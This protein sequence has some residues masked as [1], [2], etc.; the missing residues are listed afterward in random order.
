MTGRQLRAAIRK[1][2]LGSGEAWTPAPGSNRAV[3]ASALDAWCRF[4]ADKLAAAGDGYQT[5]Q[6]SRQGDWATVVAVAEFEV[7]TEDF[8]AEGKTGERKMA[9]SVV[10]MRTGLLYLVDPDTDAAA[11]DF[12]PRASVHEP[13][14]FAK[15]V[16]EQGMMRQFQGTARDYL[17]VGVNV[18]D[19]NALGE[20]SLMVAAGVHN[21][22]AVTLLLAHAADCNQ[23]TLDGASALHFAV[24]AG[25]DDEACAVV[26][27]L[28]NRGASDAK[29]N[30]WGITALHVAAFRGLVRTCTALLER[31]S[32]AGKQ[33]KDTH[34]HVPAFYAA[35]EHCSKNM[36]GSAT[37]D[38]RLLKLLS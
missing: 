32:A 33:A 15:A 11:V 9:H 23:R 3:D 22:E 35:R 14:S 19:A 24:Q 29:G 13:A 34:G 38:E 31:S 20:T 26:R 16:T 4:V 12:G 10:D 2:L 27:L 18:D 6:V 7:M 30:A 28:L 8:G 21:T 37:Y 25:Q 36:D 1:G 17:N 5:A